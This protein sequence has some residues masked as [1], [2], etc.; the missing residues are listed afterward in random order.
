M[1]LYRIVNHGD[2]VL[3]RGVSGVGAEQYGGRWNHVGCRTVYTSDTLEVAVAEKSFHSILSA[4]NRSMAIGGKIIS[5]VELSLLQIEVRESL[6]L[7]DISDQQKLS[8]ALRGHSMEDRTIL[9]GRLSPHDIL[10]EMWTRKLGTLEAMKKSKGLVVQSARSDLGYCIPLFRNCLDVNSLEITD[11]Q[12][13]KLNLVNKKGK[14]WSKGAIDFT[15]VHYST[16][17]KSKIIDVLDFPL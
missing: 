2:A 3:N 9:E 6:N 14:L 5:S 4:A 8:N 7:V 17:T 10:P 15:K 12:K 1:K 11:K 16:G 13:I